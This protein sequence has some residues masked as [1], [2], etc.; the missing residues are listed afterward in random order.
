[1]KYLVLLCA[2]FFVAVAVT[3]DSHRRTVLRKGPRGGRTSGEAGADDGATVDLMSSRPPS[4]APRWGCT[5]GAAPGQTCLAADKP[6]L[7]ECLDYGL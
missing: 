4:A 7:T 1:M 2:V 6:Q 5:E 3:A